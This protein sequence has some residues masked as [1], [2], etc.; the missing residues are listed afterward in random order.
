MGH[1]LGSE[2]VFEDLSL[3]SLSI[4]KP[5]SLFM[6]LAQPS[7]R[8]AANISFPCALTRGQETLLCF[9]K[10]GQARLTGTAKGNHKAGKSHHPS[11]NN[12]PDPEMPNSASFPA[13]VTRSRYFKHVVAESAKPLR[14]LLLPRWCCGQYACLHKKYSQPC[15]PRVSKFICQAAQSDACIP[16]AFFN[17]SRLN[18][19]NANTSKLG[20]CLH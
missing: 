3:A 4:C 6:M 20:K 1:H 18:L 17:I 12:V 13:S 7:R 19:R 2:V 16:N 14:V 9:L 8:S 15:A 10:H 5:L 11:Q